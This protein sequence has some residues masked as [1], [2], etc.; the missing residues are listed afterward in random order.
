MANDVG[1]P[2]VIRGHEATM[3]FGSGD[4]VEF[5]GAADVR[6]QQ[7]YRNEFRKQHGT[8]DSIKVEPR[9]RSEHMQNFIDCVRSRRDE[10]L[11]CNARLGYQTMVGIKMGVDA[12][13]KQKA[14]LWDAEKEE[15]IG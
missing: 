6:P 7:V 12:Y 2:M 3:F 8:V 10:D 1:L 15:T 11:N 14:I 13:R 4:D 9:P 5:D